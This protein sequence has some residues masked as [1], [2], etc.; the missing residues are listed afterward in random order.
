[1]RLL[2]L[3]MTDFRQFLGEATLEFSSDDQ[4]MVTIVHGENGVGK[5]TILNAIHWC[6]YGQ[7]LGDFEEPD[8]LVNDTALQEF[9]RTSANVELQFVHD[10]TVYRLSRTY[11][12]TTR[13][14]VPEGFEVVQGNNV[15]VRGIGRVIQRLIPSHMAPYFFFH[16]EGLVTLGT[17]VGKYGFREAIRAILGF[18]YAEKAIELLEKTRFR[19]QKQAAKLKRLDA[20]ARAAMEREIETEQ[21]ISVARDT[22]AERNQQV[23]MVESRLADIDAELAAIRISDIESLIEERQKL[24]A[25]QRQIPRELLK[26]TNS[27]IQLISRYG[28]SIFGDSTLRTGAGVLTRFRTERK[29]PAEYNDR[30]V[31]SLLHAGRCICGTE[32]PDSSKARASVEAM[33]AGASTSDQEDAV[34]SAIGI[35]ENI[36]DASSEYTKLV[37]RLSGIRQ[38]LLEEQ[39]TNSRRLEEISE[40]IA[41]IDRKRLAQR[42]ADRRDTGKLLVRL[43]DQ[44]HIDRMALDDAKRERDDARRKKRMAVD[45]NELGHHKTRL[46]FIDHVIATLREIIDKEEA[47]A[48]T[49]IE[50]LINQ[51]LAQYS[52]KDYTAE[53]A[54]DFSFRLQKQDGSS[55]AKSKGERTLLNISFIA[56]LIELAKNRSKRPHEFFVQGTVAPFVIDAPFGELDNE[57]RG[58]VATFLPESTEQLVVLLSSS[59][60][61]PVIETGLRPKTGKE[62]IL[63]SESRMPEDAGKTLDQIYIQE[64]TYQCSRYGR[65]LDRT[66]VESV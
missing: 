66:V 12:H 38:H 8:R 47:S 49:E 41:Q 62:Y 50:Q 19:W 31:N 7:T 54:D 20:Q 29:L 58:A 17:A 3:K 27:N 35:A 5:T 61:G 16:G 63:I 52:R 64:K 4:S 10:E 59:H 18:N 57:Y 55:V 13:K 46:A 32:L 56:A 43:R 2:Q 14:S 24:E 25:R 26:N 33:L 48:R 28:W 1:M 60:W 23:K 45:D 40:Q 15:P 6:L 9:A 37:T 44:R 39:G 30:F 36:T 34:N 22:Y 53:I 21:R 11:N 65:D 42:E 51:R